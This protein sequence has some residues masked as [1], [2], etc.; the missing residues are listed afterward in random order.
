[1]KVK[2]DNWKVYTFYNRKGSINEQPDY[3]RG[4]VWKERK[5]ALLIDS[6]LRGI[7]IPKIYLRKSSGGQFDYEIADGQQRFHSLRMFRDNEI[8]L[9]SD[10]EKGVELSKIEKHIVGGLTFDELPKKLRDRFD[11][12]ELTIAIVENANGEEIRTLFGRLQ[13]GTT[14]TPAEKR[15]ALISPLHSSVNNFCFNHEFFAGCKIPSSRFKHQDYLSHVIA[16]IKY[17]MTRDLKADLLEKMYLNKSIKLSSA[18]SSIIS[19]ILDVMSEID[20]NC[21]VRIVKKFNFIDV[22]WFLYQNRSKIANLNVNKF[23]K[24]YDELERLRLNNNSNPGALLE[25]EFISKF[26]EQLYSYCIAFRY[27]GAKVNSIKTRNKFFQKQYQDF[28]N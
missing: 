3:Q 16:L 14:L 8:S 2:V 19:D 23:A 1:M 7:D 11:N 26:E 17:G 21:T 9:L 22:F 13:E 27:E 5:K 6:I 10:E 20:L 18:D 24:K 25:N 15:N 4:E 12:Y 28:L